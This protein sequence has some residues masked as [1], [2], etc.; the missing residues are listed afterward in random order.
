[1][2]LAAAGIQPIWLRIEN[3]SGHDY[4]LLPISID[5]DYYSADEVALVTLKKVPKDQR[6]AHADLF[7]RT[8]CPFSLLQNPRTRVTSMRRKCAAAASSISG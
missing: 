6:A 7:R 4:W 5:P 1:M 3:T 8:P 2:P